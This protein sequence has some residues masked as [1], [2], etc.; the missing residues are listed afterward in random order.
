M[1]NK[2]EAKFCRVKEQSLDWHVDGD[3]VP[4]ANQGPTG[5]L[6]IGHGGTECGKEAFQSSGAL[7]VLWRKG[8]VSDK[9]RGDDLVQEV[10]VSFVE[11]PGEATDDGLVSL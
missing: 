8:I 4:L 1:P 3:Q 5:M 9:A 7:Y 6:D 10:P 2:A 11:R